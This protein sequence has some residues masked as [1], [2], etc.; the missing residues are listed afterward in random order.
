ML[1]LINEQLS[2]K[3]CPIECAHLFCTKVWAFL[4]NYIFCQNWIL[5]RVKHHVCQYEV[6]HIL[7]LHCHMILWICKDDVDKITNEINTY[8][9]VKYDELNHKFIQQNKLLKI[10]VE[11]TTTH[12]STKKMLQNFKTL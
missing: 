10:C 7:Y 1:S 4:N 2:W 5:G 12:V 11:K 6:Q 3:D 9:L 8:I